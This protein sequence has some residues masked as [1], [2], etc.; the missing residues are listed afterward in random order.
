MYWNL[1]LLELTMHKNSSDIHGQLLLSRDQSSRS[2]VADA[3]FPVSHQLQTQGI[4]R[5]RA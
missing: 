4:G 1:Q 2:P 5:N 3:K